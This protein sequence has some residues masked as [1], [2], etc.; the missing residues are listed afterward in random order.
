MGAD[1][2]M[3]CDE[4]VMKETGGGISGDYSLSL[5]RLAS[6]S[7]RPH[8]WRTLGT[9]SRC[10]LA[11]G[12]G[13]MKER[14]KRVLNFKKPSR[15]ITVA[16]IALVAVLSVGFAVNRLTAP[17]ELI[18]TIR[19]DGTAVDLA[20]GRDRWDGAP[21]DGEE[22]F[23]RLM[24]GLTIEDLPYVKNGERFGIRYEGGAPDSAV[25]TEFILWEDGKI[26]YN[27][28]GKEYALS[29]EGT[30]TLEPNYAT[31]LSSYSGD[32][33]EGNTVKGYRLLCVWGGNEYE[34]AFILR[35][36]PAIIMHRMGET[37]PS[38]ETVDSPSPP[39]LVDT[40][41]ETED[42]DKYIAD[43]TREIRIP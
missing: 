31:A 27:R 42:V 25:L 1:M 3:S 36:D 39:P 32:Y 12:E 24:S 2:E 9:A 14:V 16:A 38:P 21:Y 34:F 28:S 43:G 15:V 19:Q 11:F 22:T 29:T 35:G 30:V 8:P 6:S 10:P 4:R 23:E 26:K 41:S 13:G 33:T 7:P 18:V 20:K 37:H 17:D 40:G 5:V